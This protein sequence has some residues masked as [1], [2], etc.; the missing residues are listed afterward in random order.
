MN[1]DKTNPTMNNTKEP[2]TMNET[3]T[4]PTTT[5]IPPATES[6]AE[7]NLSAGAAKPHRQDKRARRTPVL[8]LA[9]VGVLLAAAHVPSCVD[10]APDVF[11]P[12]V[13]PNGDVIPAANPEP[14][15]SADIRRYNAEVMKALE[16][17]LRRIGD[18]A[19]TFESGLREKGPRRFDGARAAI[20]RI[21]DSFDGFG[22]MAGVVWDGA[23]DKV[24]G[25]D[26]LGT[27]FDKA[28][29][30]PFVQPC[31]RAGAG[32]IAD[33]ETFQAQL[34]AETEAFRE[35]LGTAYG[36]LPDAVKADFPLETLQRGM[37]RAFA[38]LRRMPLHAGA[39]AG[40]AAIEA[41]TIRST[42]ASAKRLALWFGAKAIGKAAVSAGAP[43]ADGPLPFGD[44]VAVGF[45][46]W[47]AHDIYKLQDVLPREI[48]KSLTAAVDGMQARTIDTVSDAGKKAHAAY[49]AAAQDLARA[50]CTE[51]TTLASR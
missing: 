22:P 42:A 10:P 23:K 7:E 13:L 46:I 37:N 38:D 51:T 30:G 19:A 18:L 24:L 32:L 14:D 15:C 11:K 33:F 36:K 49:A 1:N 20:P 21:R 28:L 40:A 27:R 41:A 8:V 16:R 44:A 17:H 12:R 5:P 31:A 25:G 3:T 26:R 4:T 45:A 50:A 6:T 48:A 29:D 34:E 35:E 9:L 2:M 39:V 47:T 43:A